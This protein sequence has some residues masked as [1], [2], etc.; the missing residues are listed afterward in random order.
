MHT[1][2][3]YGTED[4]PETYEP[5]WFRTFR[6]IQPIGKRH[7]FFLQEPDRDVGMIASHIEDD[8]S[9][10]NFICDRLKTSA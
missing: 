8:R 1:A 10:G 3:G 7:L 2:A 6:Y 4:K 9:C 5:Y